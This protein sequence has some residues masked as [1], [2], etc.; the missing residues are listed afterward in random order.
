MP[1]SHAPSSHVPTAL[2]GPQQ[3]LALA[4][5]SGTER[6]A[7]RQVYVPQLLARPVVSEAPCEHTVLAIEK[8]AARRR[9][10]WLC[11]G[12]LV[13]VLG[14]LASVF[15]GV[16]NVTPLSVIRNQGMARELI[17]YSRLPRTAA[18]V[19]AGSASAIAGVVMQMLVRNRFVEPAT[20]GTTEAAQAGLLIVAIHAPAMPISGMLA[21]AS[22]TALAGTALF[23]LLLRAIPLRSA[24]TVPLLGIMLAGII[25]AVTV[26]FAFRT[27]RLAML[28]SWT[29]GDFSTVIA[30]RFEQLWI[31][32]ALS[33]VIYLVANRLTVLGMGRDVATSL[34]VKY[35]PV[36]MLG[37]AM[38]AITSSVVV[39]V[40]GSL[41]FLGLVVPNVVSMLVGDN[42]RRSLPW[43]ALGGAGLVLL[44]DMIARLLV[45]P[46]EIPIGV[47][48]G[49]GGAGAFLW[50][51]MRRGARVG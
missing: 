30:G 10:L 8:A 29:T 16:A 38:V 1:C 3:P 36:M 25:G 6:S 14:A 20:M 46:H 21:V 48:M 28:N 5:A 23:L 7:L 24:V 19:L 12:L 33:V 39:V 40:V 51:L 13:L 41:P 44:A 4:T 11:L 37:L 26:F 18:I 2:A 22:V 31:V 34:G 49:V 27:D 17:L 47:V 42:L 9:R 43:V 32:G 35:R 50:L 45:F 15:I